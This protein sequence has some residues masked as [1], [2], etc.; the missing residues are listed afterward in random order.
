MKKIALILVLIASIALLCAVNEYRTAPHSLSGITANPG[1]RFSF[2][3]TGSSS[4]TVWGSNDNA[5]YFT[6]DSGLSSA[7]VHSGLITED[8]KALVTYEV[9]AGGAR[10]T[11][12]E[13][14]GVSSRNY[15]AWRRGY[16]VLEAQSLMPPLRQASQVRLN[17]AGEG[18]TI[19][20]LRGDGDAVIVFMKQASSGAAY[21]I[22]QTT[23]TPNTA[24]GYGHS[25]DDT[26]WFCVYKGTD[27]SVTVSRLRPGQAYVVSVMEY[28]YPVNGYETYN[29]RPHSIDEAPQVVTNQ[30]NRVQ[31]FTFTGSHQYFTV[32]ED[33]EQ[34]KIKVWGAGGAGRAGNY[35]NASGGSGGYAEGYLVVSPGDRLVVVV[36]GGGAF[37]A[38]DGG[39]GGWPGGGYGTKG[40][41]SGG[42][43]GGL[44]GVFLGTVSQQNALI[45]AGSGGGGGYRTGGAG[46]G[47]D[48]NM[49]GGQGGRPGTQAA[50]GTGTAGGDGAALQ[51]GNGSGE[52]L[53]GR[54]DGS[55]G[56]AGYFGGEGGFDDA[57]GLRPGIDVLAP[58]HGLDD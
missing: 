13:K 20:W 16:R 21:P 44:T 6:D 47:Y 49:G 35:N 4:G 33:V 34:I 29:T 30:R 23:Y 41:A 36:G 32:P 45:I 1:E 52:R 18:G 24:F 28:N 42:G 48:G 43:G 58:V 3:V 25:I 37:G 46:G 51:G 5:P 17:L 38:A 12:V 8:E 2:L 31:S 22:Q 39:V 55:G 57:R 11:G 26:G 53:G 54:S 10:Y 15:G 19:S 40:D 9:V 50:G 7:A 14:N 27:T 56:G